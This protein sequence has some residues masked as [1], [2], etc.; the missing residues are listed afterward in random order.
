MPNSDGADKIITLCEA[1]PPGNMGDC[2]AF[3]KA[4][5]HDLGLSFSGDADQIVGS[6]MT[7]LVWQSVA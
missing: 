5:G 1:Y 2:N 6:L 4:V 3:L 7:D